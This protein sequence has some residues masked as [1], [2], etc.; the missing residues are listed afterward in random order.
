MPSFLLKNKK[1]STPQSRSYWPH[2]L[3][4]VMANF[5]ALNFIIYKREPNVKKNLQAQ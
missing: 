3:E 2:N 1:T 4:A 5:T